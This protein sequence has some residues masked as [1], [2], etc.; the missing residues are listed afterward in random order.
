MCNNC[1]NCNNCENEKCRLAVTV[2]DNYAPCTFPQRYFDVEIRS[3]CGETLAKGTVAGGGSA[4]FD[5]PC[6]DTYSV[7]V[8]GGRHSSPRAQTRRVQCCCGR[9]SG[10][11]FIFMTFDP[12]CEQEPCPPPCPPPCCPC[13]PPCIPCPPPCPPPTASSLEQLSEPTIG[14]PYD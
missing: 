4:I 10:V 2:E 3:R 14:C 9:T 11:T 1:N 8:S 7:T 6:D 12:E 5:L 13:P